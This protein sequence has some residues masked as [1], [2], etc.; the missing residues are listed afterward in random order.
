MSNSTP[1]EVIETLFQGLNA[2]DGDTIIALYEANASMVAQPGQV[3]TGLSGV[4]EAMGGF[5]A[6][7]PSAT[8]VKCEAIT[9]GDR[10]L[11]Y[12]KWKLD[13]TDPAG[14]PIHLEGTATDVMKKQSDG[15]WLIQ[16]DNPWG[17]AILG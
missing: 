4:R 9:S 13:G 2:Q 1:E 12:T 10:S 11:V 15:N 6:L 14:E 17:A 5:L 7:K 16:I 8:L 3:V